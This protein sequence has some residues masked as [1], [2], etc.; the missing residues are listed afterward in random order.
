MNFPHKKFAAG[1]VFTLILIVALSTSLAGEQKVLSDRL[2]RLHV[3]AN[4]DSETDQ[5]LKLLVRD[6]LL[7]EAAG[8]SDMES[9][10]EETLE[11]FRATAES[12]LLENGSNYP[13]SIEL[14]KEIYGTRNYDG[15]ALPSG[16]YNSLRVIIGEGGGKN[17]WCVLFPPLC[18]SAAEDFEEVAIEAGLTED[19]I[20]LIKGADSGF[21]VKFK[22]IEIIQSFIARFS[23]K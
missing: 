15:W 18:V 12:V 20:A 1:I 9:L 11:Y 4:S 16:E 13:V 21:I 17:W 22:L 5:K 6:A 7:G 14:G 10:T 19:E 3:L 23:G 8:L 2:V